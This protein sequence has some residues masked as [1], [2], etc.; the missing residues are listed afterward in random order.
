MSSGSFVTAKYGTD[1]GTVR[2]IKIQPETLAAAFN[3]EPAGA[4]TGTLV[5]VSGGKRRIGT[6]A[7]LV[8]LKQNV[9]DVV[10]GYQPTRSITLPILSLAAYN[11][12]V[13]G[14]TVVYN[15]GNWTVSGKSPESGR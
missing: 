7:R 11:G 14:A 2:P 13:V 8:T 15:G 9:G 1:A 12:L 4:V 5:R 6:K 10:A 3:S